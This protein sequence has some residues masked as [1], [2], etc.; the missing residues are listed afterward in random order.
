MLHPLT[1]RV[2]GVLMKV[3]LEFL[4]NDL[5][6]FQTTFFCLFNYL[7]QRFVAADAAP[8]STHYITGQVK[9]LVKVLF[10]DKFRWVKGLETLTLQ[11]CPFSTNQKP[12]KKSRQ[13]LTHPPTTTILLIQTYI[14][15]ETVS[16]ESKIRLRSQEVFFKYNFQCLG[17]LDM[18]KC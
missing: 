5:K 18:L 11:K 7:H 2:K 4:L 8:Y 12:G 9:C 3:T 6:Y 16:K 10:L 15:S 17:S 14:F 1:K 13:L